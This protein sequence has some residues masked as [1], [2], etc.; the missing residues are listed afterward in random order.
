MKLVV[1]LIS[2]LCF[3]K[4]AMADSLSITPIETDIVFKG[5]K[6]DREAIRRAIGN[7]KPRFQKCKSDRPL[8]YSVEF[9]IGS[10][11]HAKSLMS[12]GYP[13]PNDKALDCIYE[14]IKSIDLPKG[15]SDSTDSV[16]VPLLVGNPPKVEKPTCISTEI[17]KNFE[18][19]CMSL[20]GLHLRALGVP[21]LLGN[22]RIVCQCV[23]EN[24]D[25]KKLIPG[26]SCDFK[27]ED[28]FQLLKSRPVHVM[29]VQGRN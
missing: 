8:K 10:D 27:T 17:G 14:L 24:F 2:L 21:R 7:A 22:F 6:F 9:Q 29:C 4:S 1:I 20:T 15:S 11:G 5:Q 25:L 16:E 26:N 3:N 18:N 28:A 12:N 23:R 19:A 13:L